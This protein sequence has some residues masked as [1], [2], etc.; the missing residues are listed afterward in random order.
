MNPKT[1]K[2]VEFELAAQLAEA[3]E[4]PMTV[5]E[6]DILTVPEGIIVHQTNALGYMGA[7]LALKV[8]QKWPQVYQSYRDSP[9]ALG[10]VQLIRV[11]SG[12]WVCNL[13]GQASIGRKRQHTSYD[14]I[15]RGLQHLANLVFADSELNVVNVYIPF[16]MG[17]GLGGGDWRIIERTIAQEFPTAILCKLPEEVAS[18][19]QGYETET[20]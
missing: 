9:P 17:A 15:Q 13:C 7:G 10:R 4:C 5:I 3:E 20:R 19:K 8:R 11:A 1:V 12:L 18:Q 14:A 16:G 2:E 6:C